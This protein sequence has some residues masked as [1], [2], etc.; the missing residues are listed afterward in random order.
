MVE[1][2]LISLY[3]YLGKAGGTALEKMRLPIRLK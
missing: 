3:D 2:G 1:N